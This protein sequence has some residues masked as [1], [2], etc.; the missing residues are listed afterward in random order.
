MMTLTE[1]DD[2]RASWEARLRIVDENLAALDAEP[3][4]QRIEGSIEALPAPLEGTTQERVGPA[5]A[6]MRELFDQRQLLAEMYRRARTLRA[7]VSP[8]WPTE[9]T[10]HGPSLRLPAID[11]PLAQRG[12]LS[13][14]TAED[15]TTPDGLLG[16]MTVAFERARDVVLAVG[17]AWERLEPALDEADTE[18]EELDRLARILGA[19]AAAEIAAARAR[20]AA[21]RERV[22]CDPLG[23]DQGCTG[24]LAPLLA[25]LRDRL[26]ALAREQERIETA[27][28]RSEELLQ[29]LREEQVAGAAGRAQ[30]RAEI[31]DTSAAEAVS[32]GRLGGLASWL[33]T[34]EQTVEAGKWRSAGLAS[35]A[36]SPQ[37]RPTW[38]HCKAHTPRSRPRSR[39]VQNSSGG[40]WRGVSRPTLSLCA[41]AHPTRRS[42]NSPPMPRHCSALVR[43]RSKKRRRSSPPTRRAYAIDAVTGRCFRFVQQR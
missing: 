34:L 18:I 39:R 30:Y 16:A 42:T 6:T 19:E 35:G 38:P 32:D 43:R 5:L 13:G 26:L 24:G 15:S 1:I 21:L 36:G 22:A 17:A 20:I 33:A 11:T 4:A 10:L 25:G 29:Q 12:L 8:L 27:L 23:V 28:V 7:S 37:R 9:R 3:A 40:C 41:V 2:A 14:A 31:A